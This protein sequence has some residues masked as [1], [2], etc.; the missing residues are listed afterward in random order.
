MSRYIRILVRNFWRAFAVL[1]IVT[2]VLVQLGREFTPLIGDHREALSRY[3]SQTL[4]VRVSIDTLH[5]HWS[6]LQPQLRIAGLRLSNHDDTPILA[7][8]EVTAELG[9]LQS[10]LQWDL[11][12]RRALFS[13]IEASFIQDES[14]QWR[15]V[16]LPQTTAA[17]DGSAAVTIDDPL[18]VF[19]FGRHIEINQANL[20]FEFRTGHKTAVQVPFILLENTQTFHRLTTRLS[21]EEQTDALQLVL[22]G[23]GDPR[24]RDSFEA[25]GYLKL[26]RFPLEKPLAAVAGAGWKNLPDGQWREDSTVDLEVWIS[27]AG[28]GGYNLQGLINI[29][30]LPWEQSDDGA[31][32]G[33]PQH[34]SS[35]VTGRWMPAAGWHLALQ[36]AQLAWP[37]SRSPNFNLVVKDSPGQPLSVHTDRLVLS[38]WLALAAD[39][40]HIKGRL[41]EVLNTLNPRGTLHNT[42]LLLDLAG[43]KPDFTLRTNVEK[44]FVEAWQGAPALE[45]VDGY[46]EAGRRGGVVGGVVELDSREGFAMHYTTVYAEP[47]RYRSAHGQ[48]AWQL[49]PEQNSIYIN[50]GPLSMRGEDGL[51]NGYFHIFLPWEKGS[52]DSHMS[53]SIGLQDSEVKYHKKYVPFLA[54]E[55]LRAWLDRALD[56]GRVAEG[57]F[58]YNGSLA[59]DNSAGR[60]MQLY[61]DIDNASLNYH[62]E[63]PPLAEVDAV[64][65]MNDG[66]VD[67]SVAGASL[68]GA[69]LGPTLVAVAPNPMGQG[70]LL[71]VK[72][73]LSGDAGDGLRLLREGQ[74]RRHLGDS[75]DRWR[76]RG[77]MRADITLSLPLVADEPGELHQVRVDLA[78][79]E[80]TMDDLDLSFEKLQGRL[81]YSSTEGLSAQ[82]I[83]AALWSRPVS[84]AITSPANRAGGRDTLVSL[85]GAVDTGT[86][87]RWTRRP[88]VLFTR[89]DLPYRAQLRIPSRAAGED[90][91]GLFNLSSDMRG[92]AVD[93]PAPYGKTAELPRPLQVRVPLRAG[94]QQFDV[95]YGD[96]AH[97]LF[98]ETEGVVQKGAVSLGGRPL[99]PATGRL[100][101]TGRVEQLVLDE[102]AEVMQR[103]ESY[104]AQIAAA[105]KADAGDSGASTS[106]SQVPGLTTVLDLNFGKLA[107]SDLELEALQVR[108]ERLDQSWRLQL[109][110]PMLAGELDWY[111]SDT[112]PLQLELDYLRLPAAEAEAETPEA[113][114]TAPQDPLAD[115]NFEDIIALDFSTR[116]L[117]VGDDNYGAWSFLVRPVEAGVVVRDLRGSVKG[118]SIQGIEENSGARLTWQRRDNAVMTEFSGRIT[119]ADLGDVLQQWGQP[120]L[121]ESESAAFE[122]NLSWPGSPA[123]VGTRALSGKLDMRAKK[124][125]FVSDN[126]TGANPLLR[127]IGLFN[128]DTWARRLKL[129][130]SDLLKNGMAYDEISG[131]MQF[132][133]GSVYL[134]D[135]IK[136]KTPSSK[137]QMAGT[138]DLD[139]EQLDTTLVATLP[140]GGNLTLLAAL[141]GG[142]PAATG[143][144]VASKIF[145]K[146]VDKVASVS[147]RISGDWV[148]PDFEFER[149]F[150]DKAA[151]RAGEDTLKETETDEP[152]PAAEEAAPQNTESAAA[153]AP[154]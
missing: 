121:I 146:Q 151:K 128:F 153:E 45:S 75:F 133:Q 129:D 36:D 127:L 67:V 33:L 85:Q 136:V 63:W 31:A 39:H 30:G 95:R 27:S 26:Q 83:N 80:L 70:S 131:E 19:L 3:L 132:D 6:G 152:A 102:W 130:F 111:D 140:V 126:R 125:R 8:E 35:A 21:L 119:A 103:Y 107:V 137:L 91:T 54:A 104:E 50:S 148:D 34:L 82:K 49:R 147:Y 29:D 79:T 124:G 112:R 10:L 43:E 86:L 93:L 92:V 20:Q 90:H 98:E 68:L 57:G 40:G 42:Q 55:S 59:R 28:G 17:S 89:G 116:E 23:H 15:V 61:L 56:K 77:R 88:E 58:I 44:V 18:D 113:I 72:G 60:A 81:N 65:N 53:L 118:A 13:E 96:L 71:G 149:L 122:A 1:L 5:A 73:T 138:I 9:L 135:P 145:K 78:D 87:A 2:A 62:A 84:V 115:W 4:G 41:G 106:A 154:T 52:A 38:D 110:N 14:G 12:W 150:D 24:Q 141:A 74:L 109:Q 97:G 37:G 120:K 66:E 76:M 142:L 123:A 114:E 134:I 69:R 144:Y 16:G 100:A 47:M 7:I 48:V 101:L 143:V 139:H 46:V 25:R 105:A 99:L 108:G 117:S 32:S 11:A 94:Q 64:V 22:E 51:V